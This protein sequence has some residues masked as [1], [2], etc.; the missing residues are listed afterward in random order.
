MNPKP[1]IF[2]N[3]PIF[4]GTCIRTGWSAVFEAG[5]LK[6]LGASQEAPPGAERV[7]LH[8]DIL[9]VGYV[10]LQINGGGG[11][12][13]NDDPSVET[14]G[15]ISGAHH[16]LGVAHFLPTLITDTPRKT[17]AAVGAVSAAIA[18]GI[19]GIAGL[20]LEG[21]HISIGRKGAHDA[22][23]IRPMTQADLEVLLDAAGRL[24]RLMVTLAP[25]SAT[26]AQ[27]GALAQAGVVVSL[28]HTDAA[29]ETASA[30][31]AAGASCVTHL[32]N[33]M[34]QVGSRAPGLA[35][36]TLAEERVSAGLIA[37]G[38]HVHPETIGLA[39]RAKRPPGR[40]F[41]VSDAM[42]VA[43]TDLDGFLLGG[44][45]VR[46]HGGALRLADGTLAGADLD[47]TSAIE[48]LVRR[49]GLPLD[50]ALAAATSVPAAVIGMDA[51]GLVAGRT[52]QAG[53]IR[54]AADLSGARP[55]E[56]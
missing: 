18:D 20:H 28:G 29:F 4:D 41:L 31:F 19:A 51:Y 48:T 25:E 11:V 7:D 37:D 1:R 42:A 49:V 2:T 27:V 21:P 38:I 13:F 35:G 50:A 34:S 3:G 9:S 16:G 32:F 10:D 5:R 23:L 56:T 30:Y 45:R 26:P 22:A 14:L 44:R 39:W 15:R 40:L 24:P 17:E 54:I 6:Y 53:A 33:A 52:P 36:A 46:R 12:H 55:L 47:L 8:G 43:G